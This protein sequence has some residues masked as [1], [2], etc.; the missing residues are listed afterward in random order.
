MGCNR[1]P[2]SVLPLRREAHHP[3]RH[4]RYLNE[5]CN[6]AAG[7]ESATTVPSSCELFGRLLVSALLTRQYCRCA[8]EPCQDRKEVSFFF[9]LV[10]H[11][12]AFET[13]LSPQ[14]TDAY[15]KAWWARKVQRSLAF[16]SNCVRRF[17][18]SHRPKTICLEPE[19]SV[20]LQGRQRECDR[21]WP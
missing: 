18:I 17:Q 12:I 16:A 11:L 5:E 14:R 10:F 1:H 19:S 21:P 2:L 7:P 8:A 4:R 9:A 13:D 20:C 3:N 6:S 15:L